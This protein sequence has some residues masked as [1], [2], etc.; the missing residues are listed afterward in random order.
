M[1]HAEDFNAEA[2][3]ANFQTLTFQIGNFVAAYTSNY[4]VLPV[5]F[6]FNK[7]EF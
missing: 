6:F 4:G 2:V 5:L 7:D 3:L 1:P